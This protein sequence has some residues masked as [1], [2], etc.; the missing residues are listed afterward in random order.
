MSVE[1]GSLWVSFESWGDSPFCGLNILYSEGE[2]TFLEIHAEDWVFGK[3]DDECWDTLGIWVKL[4]RRG[5]RKE[6]E[7]GK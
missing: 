2:F 4:H 7:A 3:A 1:W 5:Q 6:G